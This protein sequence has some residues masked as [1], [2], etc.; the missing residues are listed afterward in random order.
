MG[1]EGRKEGRCLP[2]TFLPARIQ[3]LRQNTKDLSSTD[4][5]EEEIGR[6]LGR[7]RSIIN[8]SGYASD[9]RALRTVGDLYTQMYVLKCHAL[10]TFDGG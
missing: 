9:G 8:S 1:K 5:N 6:S 10:M 7:P 4:R 3:R 2:L